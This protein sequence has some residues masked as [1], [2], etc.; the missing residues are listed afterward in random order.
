MLI[1]ASNADL[2]PDPNRIRTK[3][4]KLLSEQLLVLTFCRQS[5]HCRTQ[6]SWGRGCPDPCKPASTLYQTQSETHEAESQPGTHSG[7]N[8][9]LSQTAKRTIRSSVQYWN[10][11]HMTPHSQSYGLQWCALVVSP[12][13]LVA[14]S[15]VIDQPVELEEVK[16]FVT[17]HRRLVDGSPWKN[18]RPLEPNIS[19]SIDKETRLKSLKL[20]KCLT[21]EPKNPKIIWIISLF[22]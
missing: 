20:T 13:H 17:Q 18:Q 11:A 10:S 6:Q 3:R 14:A 9:A 2:D 22:F 12:S 19:F 15:Q 4:W 5:W 21:V 8:Q 16:V 1:S 7:T